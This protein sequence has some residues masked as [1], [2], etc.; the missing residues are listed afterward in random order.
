MEKVYLEEFVEATV[1]EFWPEGYYEG[2]YD[3]KDGAGNPVPDIHGHWVA[4][5]ATYLAEM[6]FVISRY[7]SEELEETK[8]LILNLYDFQRALGLEIGRAHV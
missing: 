4:N 5:I 8:E 2:Y 1:K 6:D 7:T 3:H